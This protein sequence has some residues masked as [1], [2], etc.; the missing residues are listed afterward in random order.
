M[1]DAERLE[2]LK[3]VAGTKVYEERRAASQK[4]IDNTEHRRTKIEELLDHIRG[5]LGKLEG[6]KEELRAF[7][8]RDREEEMPGVHDLPQ[9]PGSAARSFG[10]ARGG[11][12]FSVVSS[13]L[14]KV[15]AEISELHSQIKLL[16]EERAQLEDERKDTA[17]QKAKIKLDVQPTIDNQLQEQIAERDAELSQLLPEYTA[18]KELERALRQQITDAEGAIHR[19]YAK[20]ATH[21]LASCQW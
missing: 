20:H 12:H 15:D 19:L 4:I 10:E 1:P 9:G 13:S 21:V 3:E 6:E 16:S 17:K 5:R 11:A 8:D 7:Q 2:I 14:R 18:K